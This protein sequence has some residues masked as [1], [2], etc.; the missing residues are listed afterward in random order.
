MRT[1]GFTLLGTSGGA[2]RGRLHLSHGDVETPVFM[3]V[4]TQASVK[5]VRN[6]DLTEEG[7]NL[8]L[9]NTYHLYLRP[10]AEVMEQ[11]GGL[12]GFMSWSG[13]I[14]TD[15]GGF[16]IWSLSRFRKRSE[17]G[18]SFRSHIDGSSHVLTPEKV[19]ELQT[20]FGSDIMMVLDEC[21]EL[22]SDHEK[23]EESVRLTLRWA[24]RARVVHP[25]GN[26]AVFGIVQGGNYQDLRELCAREL[27]DMDFDGYAIGGVSV[28]EPRAQMELAVNACEPFLPGGKA[29]YLMGVGKPEDLVD[30]TAM[31]IDMFD[32]V[33]P[34]RNA[35][36]G[37]FFVPGGHINIRNARFRDDFQPVQEGCSCYVCSNH[38]RAYLRHLF[39]ARE[40][41]APVLATLHNLSYF[42][43]LMKRIRHA[44]ETGIYPE[45]RKNWH[46]SRM[47]FDPQ[48]Y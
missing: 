3:P 27:V 37:C 24:E 8:I 23:T 15:S 9:G 14:L 22:P 18:F 21:L 4:G 47:E 39:L 30:F 31:G 35:R 44:V 20:V 48:S 25:G 16:Q 42:A 13:N 38:S 36:G 32:C 34:T 40:W 1:P 46:C 17:E 45:W 19:I 2:R 43:S 7:Y 6:S 10:G 33:V 12:H 29:R 41:L 5:T 26:A 11:A 28:G